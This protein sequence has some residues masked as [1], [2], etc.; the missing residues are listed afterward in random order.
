MG[1]HSDR[2]RE[3]LLDAA[4]ELFAREGVDAVSNRRITE[5]AG[6]ANHSA[7]RYHFGTRE[8]LFAALLARGREQMAQ[9]RAQLVHALPENAS[10]RDA[11]A[12]RIL[13]WVEQLD[14]LPV[15]SWRAR[16]IQQLGSAPSTLGF[17]RDSVVPA[18]DLTSLSREDFA[19]LDGIPE[20]ILNAR[21]G[22][23]G[24]MIVGI[25]AEHERRLGEGDAVG[26]WRSVAY[27]LVDAAAGMLSAAVTSPEDFLD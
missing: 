8:D 1:Q 23:L 25:C 11:I 5:H 15:P 24:S 14:A 7:I 9:R 19:E 16:L 6:T 4:E 22:I 2:A 21:S 10:L 13:P 17:I 3:T 18:D 26:S 12:A 27:F 20:R